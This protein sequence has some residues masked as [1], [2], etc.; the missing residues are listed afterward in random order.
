[1]EIK[2][3]VYLEPYPQKETKKILTEYHVEQ[4][5]FEG[6]LFNGYFRLRRNDGCNCAP[7]V[8]QSE[9]DG[10]LKPFEIKFELGTCKCFRIRCRGEGS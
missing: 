8:I 6:V 2:K 9:I 5:P 3:I 1:V 7:T 10:E 4:A